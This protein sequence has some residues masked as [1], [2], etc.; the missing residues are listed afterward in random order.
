MNISLL[1]GLFLFNIAWVAS[2]V[3]LDLLEGQ[4]KVL[5]DKSRKFVLQTL[6]KVVRI[7]ASAS[8]EIT[9]SA[10]RALPLAFKAGNAVDIFKFVLQVL[11]LLVPLAK[12]I[13]F[14]SHCLSVVFN[15]ISEYLNLFL[16]FFLEDFVD[17]TF[18]T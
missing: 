7:V 13:S 4:R 5:D 3:L 14:L 1:N 2:K 15:F 16:V 9:R 11:D 18:A 6:Q 8:A 10:N 12:L 17:V